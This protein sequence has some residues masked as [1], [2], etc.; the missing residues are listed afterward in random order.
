MPAGTVI[1]IIVAVVALVILLLI[2]A[3]LYFRAK[4][5][6]R[7]ADYQTPQSLDRISPRNLSMDAEDG[8]NECR[9]QRGSHRASAPPAEASSEAHV[10]MNP[11]SEMIAPPPAY[12]EALSHPVLSSPQKKT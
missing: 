9:N 7:K 5:R 6:D 4:S 3:G 10:I 12:E 2:A 11:R 1:G 8:R